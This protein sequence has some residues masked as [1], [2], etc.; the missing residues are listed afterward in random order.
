MSK[1]Q[2]HQYIY[3][4]NNSAACGHIKFLTAPRTLCGKTEDSIKDD[5]KDTRVRKLKTF[6]EDRTICPECENHFRRHLSN[7]S[8]IINEWGKA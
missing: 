6:I 7:R 8:S 3:P 2:Q 4:A 1:F 5:A